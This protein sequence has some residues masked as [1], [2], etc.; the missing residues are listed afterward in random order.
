VSQLGDVRKE[1]GFYE[2]PQ[3]FDG[4]LDAAQ[5]QIR[6][7]VFHP[8]VPLIVIVAAIDVGGDR[9]LAYGSIG[10]FASSGFVAA[11][12]PDQNDVNLRR[13][14]E[15]LF[16]TNG[17][18]E[19]GALVVETL[20]S[21]IRSIGLDGAAG[22]RP[23]RLVHDLY[24]SVL[25]HTLP[26]D[27]PRSTE[28]LRAHPTDCWQS[29]GSSEDAQAILTGASTVSWPPDRKIYDAWF[30]AVSEPRHARAEAEQMAQAWDYAFA[31]VL[32]HVQDRD[33]VLDGLWQEWDP[34]L[35]AR[36]VPLIEMI[37]RDR[38]GPIDQ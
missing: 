11:E 38:R 30:K 14:L 15:T 25:P 28:L 18:P 16:A 34:N 36:L 35:M 3:V 4:P 9:L 27:L 8:Q 23:D 32:A 2:E 5:I 13:A 24:W 20:P 31:W 26:R 12:L 1:L 33:T 10:P 29:L 37:D 21:S 22:G 7:T 17:Y 19:H 6:S